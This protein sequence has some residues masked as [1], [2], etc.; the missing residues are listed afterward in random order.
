MRLG[1][2]GTWAIAASFIVAFMLSA[3]PLPDWVL[4]WRPAWV[5]LVLAYWCLALPLRLGVVIAWII[6]LLFDVMQGS[7]LGQHAFGL[8]IVAY[9]VVIYHQQIRVYPLFRQALVIGSLV[10]LYSLVMLLVYNL[11]G[12]MKYGYDYL[13]ASVTSAILWPWVFVVLRDLR[14]RA[15]V[16]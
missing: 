13:L 9:V 14:R 6:G 2:S 1:A 16:E 3:L 5:P 8:A 12:S 4:P 10:F 7:L 11:I 15:G